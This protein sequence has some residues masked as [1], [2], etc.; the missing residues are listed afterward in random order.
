MNHSRTFLGETAT[1]AKLVDHKQIEKMVKELLALRKRRGRLFIIGLGG[2]AANASHMVNDMRRLCGIEAYA[3]TDNVAELTAISNDDGWEHIFSNSLSFG[4]EKD[5]LMV[6]SVGGGTLDISLPI[7]NSVEHAFRLDMSILG[8]VGR[9][10]G[11]TDK[12]A[13]CCVIIPTVNPDRVTP[14]T[15]AFQ[16]V[17][18]HCLVSH[19]D[20][21]I[22]KTKW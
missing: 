10:G 8:I 2:S 6:L 13:D 20:L 9:N 1:I 3:P 19:P 16:A 15:E 22:R 18:W 5:A 21:Q 11:Y 14:H 4:R 7:V 17:V 12:V